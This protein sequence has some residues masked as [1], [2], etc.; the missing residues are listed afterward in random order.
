MVRLIA[1]ILALCVTA[2]VTVTSA[3]ADAT[4]VRIG[5]FSSPALASEGFY[6]D[7]GR[8]LAEGAPEPFDVTLLVRGELGSD[9]AHFYALRRG[10]L[11]IAGVGMQSV[12]TMLPELA[13]LNAAYLFSS[14]DE[15]DAVLEAAVIPYID[16]LLA[17]NGVVGLRHFGAAWHGVYA[18]QPMRTPEQL[19]GAR[20]RALIDPASQLFAQALNVDLFQIPSTEILTALQTGLINAG[21]TNSHVYNITGTSEAAPFFTRTRHTASIITLVANKRW[22]DGLTQSQRTL[23]REAYPPMREAG[24]ALRA[25]AERMLAASAED[26][27]TLVEPTE[28][29]L[30]VW[31]AAGQ[32]THGTLIEQIGGNASAF[33]DLIVDA[34]STYSAANA[35]GA[36]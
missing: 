34:K 28:S 21:E 9:E 10:R 26:Y 6:Q 7:F 23:I 17:E 30:A 19:E 8:R 3:A 32:S 14:W 33:Y 36:R 24:E 27:L 18:Q 5:A 29:E 35:A 31:R 4:P 1:A 16:A 25:D 22:F 11:D 13:V 12:T 2:T 15:F 20:F